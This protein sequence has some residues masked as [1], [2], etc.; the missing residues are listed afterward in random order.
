MA[1]EKLDEG[2]KLIKVM[3]WELELGGKIMCNLY[4]GD[5]EIIRTVGQMI[6]S[7]F[8]LDS[9]F[10]K[11]LYKLEGSSVHKRND[12]PVNSSASSKFRRGAGGRRLNVTSTR[13][14]PKITEVPLHKTKM[15]GG[16]TVQLEPKWAG[17]P[18]YT[19][20]VI[21][22][23]K[24]ELV[25]VTPPTLAGEYIMIREWD[26][27]TVR[28]FCGTSV[29]SFETYSVKHTQIPYPILYLTYPKHVH[30]KQ[31]R[32]KQRLALELIAVAHEESRG[33]AASVKISDLSVGGASLISKAP[34][35]DHGQT[36]N[37]KFKLKVEKIEVLMEVR[38]KIK[39]IDRP[40]EDGTD[41]TYGVSFSD[42]PEEME[43]ALSAFVTNAMLEET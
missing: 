2:P 7:Q 29:Y 15:R 18:T 23:L 19:V 16:M 6:S 17:A 43:I 20:R 41:T 8:D 40:K 37:L 42:I 1:K 28:Y 30:F 14:P 34:L 33:L 10:A 27:F 39:K 4:N 11:G 12:S 9:L 22:Y 35:G 26:G 24:D 21:G 3:T 31:I 5:R 32:Q 38:S 25:L 36:F 13:S